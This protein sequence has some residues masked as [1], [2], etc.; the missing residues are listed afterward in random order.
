M[1]FSYLNEFIA[2]IL[3]GLIQGLTEFL[4]ISST[5]HLDLF[6]RIFLNDRDFG[7]STSNIIQFGTTIA[8]LIYFKEDLKPIISKL[9]DILTSRKSFS[10][11]LN[12][13]KIWWSTPSK[14]L[15]HSEELNQKH[16]GYSGEVKTNLLLSQLAL[17]TVPIAILGLLMQKYVD[18]YLR[19]PGYVAIF[20]A[21]GAGILMLAENL[22]LKFGNQ[23]HDHHPNHELNPTSLTRDQV[24]MIGSFQAMA[25]FPGMSRSGSTIAG[26]LIVG[27]NR[28]QAARFAFLVGI[29]ALVL[30]SLKDLIE[31]FT[32][33]IK[34]AHF[35]PSDK[36]WSAT[37][38]EFSLTAILIA[39]VI[40]FVVGYACLKWLILYISKTD[41]RVFSY[42]RFGLSV[43][44]L[45]S[46]LIM[47]LIKK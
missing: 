19:L 25:I 35:L 18:T 39:T 20:L 26:S 10:L 1:T 21:L 32:K 11:W 41:T 24:L 42:Y 30:S 37:Q 45:L 22:N 8:L 33:A 3:I 17:A 46:I 5:A 4:P 28:P 13:T 23:K 9:K 43:V 16:L 2:A 12:D 27:L 40:A 44:I 38:V 36:Y 31:I 29:P 14:N 15:F 47:G 7:L 6:S 34:Q